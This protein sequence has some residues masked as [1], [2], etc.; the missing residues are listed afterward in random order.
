[1]E[2][3]RFPA[4]QPARNMVHF[5]CVIG[6]LFQLN[7]E[8]R[9]SLLATSPHY[10]VWQPHFGLPTKVAS[11]QVAGLSS[12]YLTM[13]RRERATSCSGLLEGNQMAKDR[14]T[15]AKRQ[16]AVNKRE[17]KA[18]KRED[19]PAQALLQETLPVSDDEARVLRIFR[20]YLM[21]VGKMLCLSGP[22]LI[23]HREGLDKLVDAGHLVPEVYKGAY[24]LTTSGFEVMKKVPH[25][26][27]TH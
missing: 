21:S 22:E 27:E 12:N 13:I 16:G 8:S 24:S 7:G 10:C 3:N 2:E 5:M 1:L 17:T 20:R 4:G 26:I 23:S 18:S 14:N 19:S 15:A 25:T 9:F 11:S 6:E